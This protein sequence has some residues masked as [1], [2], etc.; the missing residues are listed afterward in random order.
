MPR[1][2]ERFFWFLRDSMAG[3]SASCWVPNVGRRDARGYVTIKVGKRPVRAHRLSL[4][5]HMGLESDMELPGQF[6]VDHVWDWGCTTTSCVNPRHLQLVTPQENSRRGCR[7]EVVRIPRMVS[8]DRD[9]MWVASRSLTRDE[10]KSRALK[11]LDD[12]SKVCVQDS[13]A[14]IL[15]RVMAAFPER[16]RRPGGKVA[17]TDITELLDVRRDDLNEALS[18]HGI[19]PKLATT[20]T[21]V[22]KGPSQRMTVEWGA[23]SS[24]TCAKSCASP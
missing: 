5:W 10:G 15:E 16:R 14:P 17:L 1:D 8:I 13:S 6:T 4:A 18:R 23:L 11:Y 19:V 20:Q 12:S 9:D 3:D 2:V 24:A 21:L 22:G 7:S